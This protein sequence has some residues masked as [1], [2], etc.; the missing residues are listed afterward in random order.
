MSKRKG[1]MNASAFRSA[2]LALAVA[3]GL[4]GGSF[5]VAQTDDSTPILISLSMRD[6][7][8]AEV[9]EMLSL[10][11]RINILLA[12]CVDAVVSVNL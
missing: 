7:Q 8:L 6:V 2:L 1:L 12:D 3:G 5:S 10:Q 4:C 9:M 11:N